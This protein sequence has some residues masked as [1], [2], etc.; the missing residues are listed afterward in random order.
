VTVLGRQP[1]A[2]RPQAWSAA[3]IF[4]WIQSWLG[5]SQGPFSKEVELAPSLPEGTERLRVRNIAISDS[6]LILTL[7]RTNG[8]TDVHID[9]NPDG[10]CLW[11]TRPPTG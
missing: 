6:H 7:S 11:T 4:L 8:G 3:S 2:S 1:D 5:M 9:D 10:L